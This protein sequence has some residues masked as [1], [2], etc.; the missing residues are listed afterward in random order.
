MVWREVLFIF[1][2]ILLNGMFAMAEFAVISSRMERLQQEAQA[3]RR[4]ASGAVYLVQNIDRFVYA[5]QVGVTLVGVFAGALGG[6][7]VANELARWIGTVPLLERFARSIALTVVVVTITFFSIVLG[8]LVPKRIALGNPER[9]ASVLSAPMRALAQLLKPVVW[10]LG[11]VTDLILRLLGI[12]VDRR[13]PIT[14]EEIRAL[15]QQGT[16]AGVIEEVEQDMVESVFL[17]NDRQASAVMTPRPEVIWLDLDDTTEELKRRIVE[18]PFS[19]FPVGRDSLEQV[20]GEIKAKDL[21]IRTWADEPFDLEAIAT[22]PLYI[23]EIMPALNVLEEF[24][25]SGTQMA[26][27]IDEYGSVEGILTLTDILEAIVG[28]IPAQDQPEEPQAVRREDGTWL[29]DGMLTTDEF[30]R[31]F[32]IESLPREDQGLYHTLAGF[33]VMQLGRVPA[34]TDNF[35]W[36][37]MRFEVIDMDG[38]RV[39]KLLVTFVPEEERDEAEQ[40]VSPEPEDEASTQ[41]GK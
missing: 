4:G 26:L 5:V 3:G 25:A 29:V 35:E 17:L 28:D 1:L 36:G 40:D 16:D 23:P 20:I 10:F 27:V 31:T 11:V 2:L 24:K 15:L 41:S 8:E 34:S 9:V 19:R 18:A 21:L 32:D 6:A 14:E 30:K 39:D 12:S 33:A 37:G 38:P 22:Q 7:S 13:P